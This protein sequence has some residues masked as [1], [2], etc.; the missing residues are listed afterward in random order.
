MH[1]QR[2]RVGAFYRGKS[3][4]TVRDS[5]FEFERNDC[6]EVKPMSRQSARVLCF[7]FLSVICLSSSTSAQTA[8]FSGA[9]STVTSNL[10]GPWGVA[11]DRGGNVY[12][13]D[14]GNFRV[15]KET[16]TL[17]GYTESVFVDA[18]TSGVSYFLPYVVTVDGAGDVFVLNGGDGQILKF[19]AGPSGYAETTLPRPPISYGNPFGI[20][21]DPKGDLFFSFIYATGNLYELSPVSGAYVGDPVGTG[22]GFFDVGVAADAN[23]N[24]YVTS[25]IGGDIYK[26]TLQSGTYVQSLLDSGYSDP[27]GLAVNSQGAVYVAD[28]G[29][30]V[31][32]K[33]TPSAGKYVKTAAPGAGLE[34]PI[35]V[36]VDSL[37]DL[38]VSDNAKNRVTVMNGL[39]GIFPLVKVGSTSTK[40]ISIIFTFDTAGTLGSTSVLQGGPGDEFVDAGTGSCTPGMTY[41]AGESCSVDV[42]FAPRTQ[43]PRVGT[44]ELHRES[45]RVIATGFVAG[46]GVR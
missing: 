32:W 24:V 15:L 14:E 36:A 11:V 4:R 19:A 23:K 34:S 37:N 5:P 45:G 26:E 6:L 20:A 42:N 27:Y 10:S 12:I 33:E 38:Y 43:V 44:V 18:A 8:H 13:A 41:S 46:T 7:T 22:L 28:F 29:D 2:S 40:P 25:S 21:A 31:V 35:A 17:Y 9:Q 39:G 30:P 1:T 16:P 3:V